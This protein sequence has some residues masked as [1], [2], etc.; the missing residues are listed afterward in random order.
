MN[1]QLIQHQIIDGAPKI[2]GVKVCSAFCTIEITQSK[3]ENYHWS[4][5]VK[6]KIENKKGHL[7]MRTAKLELLNCELK[8]LAEFFKSVEEVKKE[9]QPFL[10]NTFGR[11]TKKGIDT[12]EI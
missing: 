10:Y 12:D 4:L 11:E 5:I 7:R 3:K 9:A 8:E 1:R 2:V 6:G